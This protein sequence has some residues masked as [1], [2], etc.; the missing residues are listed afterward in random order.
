VIHRLLLASDLLTPKRIERRRAWAED[1]NGYVELYQESLDFASG[2][3]GK[4][5][6]TRFRMRVKTASR[7]SFV[8]D[9]WALRDYPLKEV[10]LGLA[11]ARK[12][13]M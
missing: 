4:A 10:A 13:A 3:P 2:L 12:P 1:E 7:Q 6:I 9:L 8:F 11:R 5:I